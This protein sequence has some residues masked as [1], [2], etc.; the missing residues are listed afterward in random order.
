MPGLTQEN[1]S[2][3]FVAMRLRAFV[4]C[5]FV[6]SAGSNSNAQVPI[7][8]GTRG[9]SRVGDWEVYQRSKDQR[10][11]VNADSILLGGAAMG[12]WRGFARMFIRPVSVDEPKIDS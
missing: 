2:A 8:A 5:K 4:A 10:L 3:A 1:G 9:G 12:G 11:I 7:S 6:A